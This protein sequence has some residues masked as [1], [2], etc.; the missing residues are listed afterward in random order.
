MSKASKRVCWVLAGFLIPFFAG[1]WAH[2]QDR[3]GYVGQSV[4]LPYQFHPTSEKGNTTYDLDLGLAITERWFGRTSF[5]FGLQGVNR[6]SLAIGPEFHFGLAS[7][8]KPLITTQAVYTFSPAFEFGVRG[9]VGVEWDLRFLTGIDNLFL[10]AQ[11]GVLAIL[12][13]HARNQI[14]WETARLGLSWNY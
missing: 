12:K 1:A 8:L 13:R 14:Y 4:I 11:T 5:E 9:A 7:M 6:I 10:C 2:A 3:M